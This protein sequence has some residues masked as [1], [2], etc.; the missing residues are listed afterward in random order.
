[1]SSPD[2]LHELV[3]VLHRALASVPASTSPVSSSASTAASSSLPVIA[4]P[5]ATPAPYSGSAEDCNGFLLQCSLALEMQPHLYPD[6]RAKV[7]FIISHLDGKALCWAEPL[8]TQNNPIVSSL[9]SFTEHFK[10]VFGKPAWD[11]SLATALLDS[12]SAGNFISGTF[13]RQLHLCTAAT[14]K[15]YQIHAVTGRP[16]RQVRRLAE[17]LRLQI[18]ALHTE[19]TYLL[20]LENSTA[21]VVL[22]RPWLEQH[23]PILSWRT[24]E[25]LR[26]GEHCFE[27]CFPERPG[28]K[29]SRIHEVQGRSIAIP[30]CYSRFSDVFCPKKASKLPPPRP[31]DCAIDLIPGE[32]V[33]RGR[34]YSLS[35]PEEKAME[36]YI[37][38]ALAQGYIRPSTSPAASSF[39]FV[40]KKDGGLRPCIDYR[41]L[42]K[43][44]VKFRYPLPL[45]PAVL[46]CLRGATVF[47]KLDLRSLQSHPDTRGGRVE[48]HVR[49]PLPAIM[50]IWLCP[51]D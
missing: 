20:V 10:E 37:T 39:F 23:D 21:D 17:P 31:W 44:T 22:G 11:P 34:I 51:T 6:D 14:P 45:V 7:V 15:V 41:A 27:G 26:W 43:I 1:M 29:L 42:N 25:V 48:D 28:P 19:E 30:A 8:W 9:S 36:E 13:C 47:T 5:M 35:L 49:D 24:G 33:P 3:K 46:E 2:P 40:A 12:G 50:N 38:E 16:L 32:P 18:R 4:S